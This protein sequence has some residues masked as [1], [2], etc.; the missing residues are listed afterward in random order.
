[1]Q[2]LA[3]ICVNR[4]VFATMLIVAVTVIGAFSYLTLGVDQFPNVDFPVVTVTIANEGASAAEIETEITEKVEAT[5]NSISGVKEIRSS[6]VEGN[7]Q[8]NIQF[9][10][11]KNFDVAAQEVRDKVNLVI[12]ELP[13]TIE[14][15]TVQKFETNASPV[16][17]LAISSPRPLRE[18]TDIVRKQL[19]EKLETL[20]GIG[21][22][23]IIGGAK[24][25][26]QVIVDPV[27]L[28]AYHLTPSEVL[29][30]IRKQNAEAPGGSL[31][32]GPNERTL[33]T[34]GKV[35]NPEELLEIPVVNQGASVI[36]VRDVATIEDAAEE[37]E[38]VTAL[39]GKSAV[40]L[41]VSKRA[42]G[43]AVAVAES[44]KARLAE[45]KSTLPTDVTITEV[46]DK[47]VFIKAAVGDVKTHL[48]EG[49]LLAC[50]VVLLF[51]RRVGLTLVAALAI[52][53]SIIGTFG[54]M[55]VLG[56]TLDTITL[57]A[58]TLM[59]G[60]VI[61]DAIV[62]LENIEKFIRE[63]GYSPFEA[64]IEATRE[65]GLA[66]LA[67]TLS[68]LAVFVPTIFMG[69]IVG[70]FLAPFGLTAS[71]AVAISMFVSFTLTPM[72]CARILKAHPPDEARD[73]AR[74]SR[75]DAGYARLVAWSLR[76]RWLVIGA[77]AAVTVSIVPLFT[78]VGKDFIPQ[79]DESQFEVTLRAP[80]GT[81]LAATSILLER[82]A[83]DL[84]ALPG[85]SD[86]LTIAGSGDPAVS[87]RGYIYV[88]L[89]PIEQRRLSQAE[90]VSKA[91]EVVGKYPGDLRASVQPITPFAGGGYENT[92]IQYVLTGPDLARLSTYS[93]ELME[94]MRA[95]QGVTDVNSTLDIGN[96]ET[97][98]TIDR[99]R[100]ADAG[101]AIDDI[102]TSLNLLVAGVEAS[103]LT[104]GTEQF[105][106]RMRATDSFRSTSERLS[107]LYVPSAK[108]GAVPLDGLVTFEEKLGPAAIQ[109]LNRQRYVTVLA[110][111]EPGVSLSEATEK[112]DAVFTSLKLDAGYDRVFSGDA[113]ELGE[114]SSNF[115]L[116]FL[117][118]F[119]FM[120]IVLAAQ[121]ESFI[122]P[123]T[124]LLTLPLSI[125]F[126]LLSLLLANQ[127][128]NLFSGLGVLVLFAVVKK[129]A[130]LQI[131]HMNGLRAEGM[132][133]QQA[134]ILANRDRLRPILM[135]TL[136]FVV[137]M[138]PLVFSKGPGATTN[139]SIGVLVLGGQTL[140]LLLTL[141]AVP[142]FY[143][144]FDDLAASPLPA[145]LW[146]RAATWFKTR[147]LAWFKRAAVPA[148]ILGLSAQAFSQNVSR[149]ELPVEKRI[150]GVVYPDQG[151]GAVQTLTPERA[152]EAALE[153]N[154]S[155]TLAAERRAEARGRMEQARGA[156]LPNIQGTISRTNN[157][158]NLASQ[159]L[160][161]IVPGLQSIIVFDTFDA[162]LQL[163]QSLFDLAAIRRYEASRG[164]Q[165]LAELERTLT[166]RQITG[167]TLLAYLAVLRA[168]AAVET[169][170]SNLELAETLV[171]LAKERRAAGV[172]TQLDV[173]RAGSRQAEEA[174]R[175]AQARAE[176]DRATLALQR[177][178]GLPLG[179][180][181]ILT[182]E[183]RF[184]P[185]AIP[186]TRAAVEKALNDR[187]EI[188]LA[189][190]RKK[191]AN[192]E[193]G[194]AR[195]ELAPKVEAF[196]DY[197][198]NGLRPDR[199]ALPTRSF[200]VRVTVPIFDGGA[201]FGRILEEK[202]KTR[203][204]ELRLADI[205][206]Q[207]AQDVRLSITALLTAAEQ[208]S[209]A[210]Q[211]VTLAQREL[212]LA[213]ER[214]TV[215]VADNVEVTRAQNTLSNARESRVEALTRHVA[216]RIN[217]S[218]ALGR[219]E[220]FQW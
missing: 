166:N 38:S 47:S 219:S 70:R 189:E 193:A 2:K 217:L 39:N 124:I 164:Q 59:V 72:L 68:L 81:S 43:N 135:T 17:R 57:L 153:N 85:V 149:I 26:I 115:A 183:L 11:G 20:D 84:R 6:S 42:G 165:R 86:A 32:Q 134:I 129:N 150:P 154:L 162:R 36:R 103:S 31:K 163:T 75:L 185:V 206:I 142:V 201:T 148:I 218:L 137:G 30:A 161:N 98:G 28:R 91:R 66:V 56:Y 102:A 158:V 69:G 192:L 1:M 80:E 198:S 22:V 107:E 186:D 55:A 44:V 105:K 93:K 23:S 4:P 197:G 144:L 195:A 71:A 83:S 211:Q 5:V 212:E 126:G 175:L 99:R 78:L 54:I 152:V 117:L 25:Q 79:D 167:D 62:V 108:F 13:K 95:I 67:T 127:S 190:E 12:P 172:A 97:R 146:N 3:E 37:P 140:C 33:R 113:K 132:P 112:I 119:I 60:V 169:S 170:K 29:A 49:S 125:P 65:I 90:L 46:G 76:H 88:K 182:G 194:A 58:L 40:I 89:L 104:D 19:K 16:I 207:V 41:Q 48:I 203:Q 27:R 133:R 77:C 204:E 110:N 215:G 45:L 187:V 82:I 64:A 100:A 155:V 176:L 131:D 130:I 157:S 21:R 15:P 179:S 174:F 210:E 205:R 35:S 34:L 24:R 123:I 73:D 51:L 120:Y 202:S 8:V 145:R 138:L 118:T 74:E 122:H 96:P 50:L 111:V 178:T 173:L 191:I 10:L 63:K 61:D 9:S 109:R 147:V 213:R 216:A 159:G 160:G 114:A 181:M 101:V 139:H 94:K 200:G 92:T 180:E 151:T 171:N 143:E 214:F 18:T 220:N 14:T 168:R 7:S 121:F 156:L 136:A 188:V 53:T 116:A 87:S 184:V 177:V 106:I 208:V 141:L 199:F 128:M 196:A 52:P 209:V